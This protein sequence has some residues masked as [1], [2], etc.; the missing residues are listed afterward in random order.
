MRDDHGYKVGTLQMLARR[1]RASPG[2][3]TRSMQPIRKKRL[4]WSNT[5]LTLSSD[6][7]RAPHGRERNGAKVSSR[8]PALSLLAAPGPADV[9]AKMKAAKSYLW[10]FDDEPD[11]DDQDEAFLITVPRDLELLARRAAA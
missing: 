8:T 7:P 1:A 5:W 3:S 11:G 9:P 4:R 6:T 10:G 2:A